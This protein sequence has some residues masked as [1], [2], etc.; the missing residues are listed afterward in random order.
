MRPVLLNFGTKSSQ[1]VPVTEPYAPL[2]TDYHDSTDEKTLTGSVKRH[3]S[4]ARLKLQTS[5]TTL[6]IGYVANFASNSWL[7]VSINGVVQAVTLTSD[8]SAHTTDVMLPAGP[9]KNVEIWEG[10]QFG[11]SEPNVTSGGVV[12]SL[13]A[14]DDKLFIIRPK[15]PSRRVVVYGDSISQGYPVQPQASWVGGI[16][17]SPSFVGGGITSYGFGGRAIYLDYL[18][19]G[20][21]AIAAILASGLN[22]V[23]SGGRQDLVV[24]IGTNDWGTVPD[25]G[26]ASFQTRIATLVDLVHASVPTARIQLVSPIVR[27]GEATPN[28]NGD[29]LS[30]YRTAMSNVASTRSSFCH[31]WDA[32]SVLTLADLADGV[33]PNAGGYAKMLAFYLGTVLV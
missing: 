13:E 14:L 25:T 23:Q 22:D 19:L 8:G 2:L 15:A 4:F 7:T 11:P 18:T 21:A 20:L 24:A 29:T 33:H 28:A 17:L 1:L 10:P 27:N 26:V 12:T 3:N 6:R 30:A 9:L 31:Y 5:G 32:S 16:R